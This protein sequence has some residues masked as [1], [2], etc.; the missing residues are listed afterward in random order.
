MAHIEY[1]DTQHNCLCGFCGVTFAVNIGDIYTYKFSRPHLYVVQCPACAHR[2]RLESASARRLGKYDPVQE[3]HATSCGQSYIP[4]EY[5]E[6]PTSNQHLLREIKVLSRHL[7]AL[8]RVAE[9][10]VRVWQEEWGKACVP[11]QMFELE[12]ILKEI[13]VPD[14]DER[15]TA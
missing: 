14:P 15:R 13:S 7:F 5:H 10:A 9:S 2:R 12:R 11:T 6:N 8:K 4:T 1:L 3:I